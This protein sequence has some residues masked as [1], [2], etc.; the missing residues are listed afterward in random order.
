MIDFA[1]LES[2]GSL[3]TAIASVIVVFLLW[4]TV[5]QMEVT[6]VLSKLQAE[7]RF[8]PWVG[9]SSSIQ[10]LSS[11]SDSTQKEKYQF[12]ITIKNFGELPANNVVAMFK[13]ATETITKDQ[14]S[15][16]L[17]D[18]RFSLGPLLPYMEK[19]YWFFIDFDLIRKAKE[20]QV[21]IYIMLYF[22]Y[23]AAG[24]KN[25]YG[26]VSKYDP[27]VNGFA[28]EDMWVDPSSLQQ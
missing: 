11:S 9:P 4:K 20:K 17:L 26:M 16:L 5:K 10:Y 25:G 28:H 23:D 3:A 15:N 27:N 12:D 6:V 24:Q 19:H 18:D 13:I 1:I 21:E 2:F 7:H 8:R 22:E 14:I